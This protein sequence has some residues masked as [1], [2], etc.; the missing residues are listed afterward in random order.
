MR[1]FVMIAAV[2]CLA[3]ATAAD[4]Q[5]AGTGPSPC[6]YSAADGDTFLEIARVE[7]PDRGYLYLA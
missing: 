1:K 4:A 6:R 2:G 5:V 3:A 7:Q